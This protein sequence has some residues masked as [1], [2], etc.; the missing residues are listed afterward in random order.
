MTGMGMGMGDIF[1]M[2]GGAFNFISGGYQFV[3]GKKL[4]NELERPDYT[5]PSEIATNVRLA[6]QMAYEG[7]PEASKQAYNREIQRNQA[8]M[9]SSQGSLN[10]SLSGLA[11]SNVAAMDAQSRL[12]VEDANMR[13]QGRQIQMEA[14]KVMAQYKDREFAHEYQNYLEDRDFAYSLMGSGMQNMASGLDYAGSGASGLNLGGNKSG[15]GGGVIDGSVDSGTTVNVN[16]GG[17]GSGN[18][19]MMK[20]MNTGGKPMSYATPDDYSTK[21]GFGYYSNS[22]MIPTDPVN[23]YQ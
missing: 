13:R 16:M 10:A 5:K 7:M 9:L 6:E 12:Y 8:A 3:K 2:I 23:L 21:E 1:G 15:G 19:G 20:D 4:M 11:A 18:P 22:Y 17:F 14:N